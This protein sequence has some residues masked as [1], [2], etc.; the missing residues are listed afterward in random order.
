[1]GSDRIEAYRITDFLVPMSILGNKKIASEIYEDGAEID[2]IPDL[3]NQVWVGVKF[4]EEDAACYQVHQMSRLVWQLHAR[5]LP[6]YRLKY[7]NKISQTALVW[8]AKNIP[9]LERIVCLV[10]KCHRN[11][12]LHARRVGLTCEGLIRN[13]YLKNGSVYDTTIYSIS[14]DKILEMEKCQQQQ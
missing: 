7:A 8:C 4:N 3:I 11:V 13:S 5:V 1:M 12:I 10:P 6:E 2:Q 9:D 14:K